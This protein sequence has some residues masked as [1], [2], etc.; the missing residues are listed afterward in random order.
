MWMDAQ[1]DCRNRPCPTGQMNSRWGY[2][3]RT[4]MGLRMVLL[5]QA[6]GVFVGVFVAAAPAPPRGPRP[7][8]QA[9]HHVPIDGGASVTH[10]ASDERWRCAGR[11]NCRPGGTRRGATRPRLASDCRS[12]WVH[13]WREMASVNSWAQ[14]RA[15]MG[16]RTANHRSGVS[17]LCSAA[18]R[19]VCLGMAGDPDRPEGPGGDRGTRGVRWGSQKHQAEGDPVKE[20]VAALS[21]VTHGGVP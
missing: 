18:R 5:H 12:G 13:A 1:A 3:W 8:P 16:R 7:A 4:E 14:A 19:V 9:F 17:R 15:C 21:R 10:G 20:H 11:T 6:V 2:T